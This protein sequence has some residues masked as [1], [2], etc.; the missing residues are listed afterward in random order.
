L[1]KCGVPVVV[2]PVKI[3]FLVMCSIFL[4]YCG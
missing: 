3:I 2:I 1:P 4:A